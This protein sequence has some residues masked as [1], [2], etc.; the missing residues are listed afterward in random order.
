LVFR[1]VAQRAIGGEDLRHGAVGGMGAP[2]LL[3]LGAAAY[4]EGGSG[5]TS[6]LRSSMSHEPSCRAS[7][8]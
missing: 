6:P 3:L 1:G 8:P 7:M 5:G 2:L 4:G